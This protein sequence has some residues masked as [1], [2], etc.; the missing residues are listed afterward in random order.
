MEDKRR[1]ADRIKAL[2]AWDSGWTLTQ[3]SEVLLLDQK[4]IRN[5]R[6]LYEDGF[7][8]AKKRN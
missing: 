8:K 2:L 4:T 7:P 6:K 5:Y 1:Y 3:I